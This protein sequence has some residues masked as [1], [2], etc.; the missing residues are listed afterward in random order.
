MRKACVAVVL[1]ALLLT[2]S[3]HAQDAPPAVATE[4]AP[5]ATVVYTPDPRRVPFRHTLRLR[6]D[7]T[8]VQLGRVRVR[9]PI[10]SIPVQHRRTFVLTQDAHLPTRLN[11]TVIPAG[12][13]GYEAAGVSVFV[14]ARAEGRG[15]YTVR[16]YDEHVGSVLCFL[17][18]RTP[19]CFF[20]GLQVDSW[21]RQLARTSYSIQAPV[22]QGAVRDRASNRLAIPT[23]EFNVEDRPLTF[24]ED[25]RLDYVVLPW[26]RTRVR[27]VIRLNGD[28]TILGAWEEWAP[29]GSA[30]IDTP[31]GRLRLEQGGNNP[32]RV[33]ASLTPYAPG[34]AVPEDP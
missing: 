27:M 15:Y 34:D 8:R 23:A 3:A 25:L 17:P 6:D 5:A 16:Y 28:N 33:V 18:R 1:N 14:F 31:L 20:G 22:A 9:D 7:E 26:T 2:A 29:D 4:S 30:E 13:P 11:S 32:Q 10:I 24:A 12:T 19:R 21:D